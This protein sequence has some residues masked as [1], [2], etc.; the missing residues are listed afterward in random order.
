MV[1]KL[2]QKDE[3]QFQAL[4][5][6]QG[7]L[8]PLLGAALVSGALC[9]CQYREGALV[10]ALYALP[11]EFHGHKGFILCGG[12]TLP[13]FR[14]QGLMTELLNYAVQ[15][16]KNGGFAFFAA[17]CWPGASALAKKCGFAASLSLRCVELAIK[18]SILAAARQD[19]LLA[20]QLYA[21]RQK[22]PGYFGLPQA[23]AGAVYAALYRAG[24]TIL[25]TED[26]LGVY[27]KAEKTLYFT[28][29]FAKTDSAAMAL[30]QAARNITGC[31]EAKVFLSEESPLF[32]G[33]GQPLP[34]AAL[35]LSGSFENAFSEIYFNP[36]G[37]G[38][39]TPLP[40]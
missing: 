21:L 10:S 6:E 7:G 12:Y 38:L 2:A 3:G 35:Y 4:L 23:A 25:Q 13:A 28:E 32:L 9:L 8:A 37:E 31:F 40:G 33:Q 30:L 22:Q 11:S 34:A 39:L 19:I 18:P 16:A 36:Y 17:P 1:E 24:G 27:F 5:E 15:E 20:K 14:R 29:L 26:A